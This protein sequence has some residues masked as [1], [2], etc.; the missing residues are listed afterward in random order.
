M[1][2]LA[3]PASA[4]W[5]HRDARQG[6][7]VANFQQDKQ[8]HLL[9]G[10][11]TAL[12][13]GLT[14]IIDY[15]I[16]VDS[17]WTTRSAQVSSHSTAGRRTVLLEHDG[18]GHWRLNGDAFRLL[19][20]CLDVDLESSAMT[21]ALPVHRLAL[22]TGGRSSAP[23]AYVRVDELA[24]DRL[25]QEYVRIRS[26]EPQRRYDYSAPAFDFTSQLTYDQHGLVLLYPGI[27]IRAS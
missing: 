6:F 7:E 12:Q 2:F 9:T 19:D 8:G 4:A 25:E 13:D 17:G 21:N 1:P 14:W 5:T 18:Q 11:T 10:C 27:A 15:E 24:V 23:A 3:L 16:R 26:Q 20:G 22:P